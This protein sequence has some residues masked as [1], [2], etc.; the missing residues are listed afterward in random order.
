MK[1]FIILAAIIFTAYF[2]EAKGKKRNHS[3]EPKKM[4]KRKHNTQQ[5]T[6]I[7]FNV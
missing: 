4:E 6:H 3:K 5:F 2:G 1:G 7:K